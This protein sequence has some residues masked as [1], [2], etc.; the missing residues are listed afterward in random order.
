MLK[1][2]KDSI[3]AELRVPVQWFEGPSHNMYRIR[4]SQPGHPD[5]RERWP[6]QH[7][8]L[9]KNLLL[10]HDVLGKRLAALGEVAV[11]EEEEDDDE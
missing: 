5:A 3:E 11:G 9:L 2:D 7:Q 1:N 6:E 10:F 8:W 4:I